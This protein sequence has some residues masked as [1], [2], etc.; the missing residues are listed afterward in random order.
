[1]PEELSY[2]IVTPYSIRKSRTGGIVARL[3][4]RT[5]LDIVGARMFAPSKALTEKYASTIVTDPEPRHR[6]TQ[7]LIKEYVLKQFQPDDNGTQPR[8]LLLVF[9]GESAVSKIRGVVG[10]IVNERTSGETIRDTYGDYIADKHGKVT[11]FE[12]AVLAPPDVASAQENLKL[13]ASY[14]DE[15]SGLMDDVID[16]PKSGNLQ[17]TLVLIKPDNFRF[18]NSRPGGVI[19]LFSRTGLYIIGFKVHRMSVAQ[20]EEFYRPV[21]DVL[22]DRLKEPSGIRAKMAFE[23][24]FGFQLS[25]DVQRRLGDLLGPLAGR[26]NWES[27]VNFMCGIKPSECPIERRNEPGTEK[28]IAIVYQGIDAVRKIREVLGPTDPS[29]APPGSIRREYGSTIMVNAAHASDSPENAV[30]EM[31]IIQ[32]EENNL[33]PL[34]EAHF[35]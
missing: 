9:R 2:V 11:Y 25:D 19:D 16:F 8:V 21:L 15:D 12:P 24:E 26:D 30:R 14:S 23:R 33:K 7:A 29:K 17:K 20:A 34:I 27:I 31:K 3:I 10:H 6:A 1:M 32:F 18:P 5:G 4:S 22:M 35:A 13:W 28:C